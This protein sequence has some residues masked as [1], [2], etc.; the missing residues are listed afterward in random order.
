MNVYVE[1]NFVLELAFL[2][3]QCSSC[4]KILSLCETRRIQL[5]IPAYS[6]AEPYETLTRRQKRR[7][8]IKEEFDA[9]LQQIARTSAYV[10]RLGDLHDLT[11]LLIKLADEEEMRLED[12]RSRLMRIT[13]VIPLDASVVSVAAM[14]YQQTHGFSPQDA[15]VYSSVLSHLERINAPQSCFLNR[16]SK[17]FDN[18]I[19]VEQLNGN[20]CKLL[21]RFDSD[22]ELILN[23]LR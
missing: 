22:H 17:E 21:P 20:D 23:A 14:Q 12:V 3:E 6:L 5:L 16:N 13:E 15:L 1:S 4:E 7:K 10:D 2:Q 9:E 19:V 18:Q 11:A 8:R